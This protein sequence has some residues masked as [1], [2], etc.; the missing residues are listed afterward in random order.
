MPIKR[1]S[2]TGRKRQSIRL[3]P[4]IIIKEAMDKYTSMTELSI[5]AG[6]SRSSVN[7][8]TRG[9]PLTFSVAGKIV[10]ALDLSINDCYL[11]INGLEE[12]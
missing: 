4:E 1:K 10:K 12:N 2:F 8:A 3:D 5:K 6:V 7:K 9:E 11:N